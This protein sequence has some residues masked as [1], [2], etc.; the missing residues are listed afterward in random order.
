[1]RNLRVG[2]LCFT[3]FISLLLSACVTSLLIGNRLQA[4]LLGA[5]IEPLVGFN[6]NEVDFFEVPMVKNRMTALLGDKYEP[7][8]KLLRTAQEIKK[9][10]VLYYVASRYLPKEM[11]EATDKAA[12]VWNSSTNQMAVMLIKNGMPEVISEQAENAKQKLIPTLPSELQTAYDKAK[13][14]HEQVQQTK[15]IIQAPDKILENAAQTLQPDAL[16]EDLEKT[17]VSSEA[18]SSDASP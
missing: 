6:P 16:L 3:V 13:Q 9:E 1:M 10:G 8:M 4:N 11:T 2:K 14:V 18:P 15:S 5:L 12:M 7:T 17:S